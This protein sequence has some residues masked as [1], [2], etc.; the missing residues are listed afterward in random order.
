MQKNK[1][2]AI[3][4]KIVGIMC[5]AA[6]AANTAPSVIPAPYVNAFAQEI[7]GSTVSVSYTHLTLPTTPEV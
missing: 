5:I 6:L 3:R 4:N 2:N 1:R 7:T